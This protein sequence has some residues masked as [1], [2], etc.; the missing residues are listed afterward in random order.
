MIRPI[1]WLRIGTQVLLS[2]IGQVSV[3]ALNIS[4]LNLTGTIPF[5]LGN[6]SSLQSLNL[7]C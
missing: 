4:G 5:Q 6:L 2:V 1:S 3:T 7:S